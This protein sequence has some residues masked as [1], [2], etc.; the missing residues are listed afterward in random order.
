MCIRDRRGFLLAGT[1]CQIDMSCPGGLKGLRRRGG[2]GGIDLVVRAQAAKPGA[3]R[4]EGRSERRR[5]IEPLG[6]EGLDPAGFEEALRERGPGG[7]VGGGAEIG[8]ED[9]WPR[10]LVLQDPVRTVAQGFD[11]LLYTSPSPRD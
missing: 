2:V 4:L 8:E 3:G 6:V 10:T 5:I 11:C 7:E 9:S 1:A